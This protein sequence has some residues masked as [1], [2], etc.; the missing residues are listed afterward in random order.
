MCGTQALL[1]CCGSRKTLNLAFRAALCDL[2]H[3]R[4][5]CLKWHGYSGQLRGNRAAS[6]KLREA[7]SRILQRR[8]NLASGTPHQPYG[9]FTQKALHRSSWETHMLKQTKIALAAA[10]AFGFAI[11]STAALAAPDQ[12]HFG[13]KPGSFVQGNNR[14]APQTTNQSR[15]FQ[16]LA[17]RSPFIA[18]RTI[19]NGFAAS[20]TKNGSVIQNKGSNVGDI[21]S[22]K[23]GTGVVV[24]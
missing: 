9:W 4:P 7:G 15:G 18:N 20:D 2:D 24:L 21:L 11:G 16:T 6:S 13:R 3:A 1:A 5:I 17:N 12:T 23:T 22:K 19:R 14:I 10:A 8:V